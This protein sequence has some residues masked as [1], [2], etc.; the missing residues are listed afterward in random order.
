MVQNAPGVHE[1]LSPFLKYVS[2]WLFCANFVTAEALKMRKLVRVVVYVI[3]NKIPMYRHIEYIWA[4]G[5]NL[6]LSAYAK[7]LR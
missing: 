5:V 1:L 6:I 7:G 2:V 3:C 4:S